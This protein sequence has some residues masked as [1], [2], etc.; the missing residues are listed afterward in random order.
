MA[1]EP[2]NSMVAQA[3]AY[4]EAGVSVF[5]CVPGEKRPL[6]PRGYLDATTDAQQIRAWWAAHPTA[7]IASPTGAPGFDALDVDVRSDGNGWDALRRLRDEGLIAGWVRAVRTPSGGLHLHY[8]GTQQ[9]NGS[10]RGAHLDFRGLGGYVL[11]PPSRITS[12]SHTG[13]YQVVES[14]PGPW[15][16]LDWASAVRLLAPQP[17]A[18]TT[19]RNPPPGVDSMTPLAAHVGR[20]VEGN[21][22]NALFWAACRAVEAGATDL[23]P[24]VQAAVT[25]GLPE[26]QA[27]RTVRSAE[28]TI[29]RGSRPANRAPTAMP[30][31]PIRS[32]S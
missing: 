17:Q 19:R 13:I 24:L 20:Q 5:P 28:E 31:P 11:L 14:A 18:T 6:T 15:R 3:L 25:A 2:S 7:N 21:R 23:D 4:A 29:A 32:A 22:D 12:P 9:R 27:R 30:N 8:L 16:S 10:L 26:R 1:S